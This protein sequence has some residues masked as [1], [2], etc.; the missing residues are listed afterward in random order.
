[1]HKKKKGK[2]QEERIITVIGSETEYVLNFNPTSNVVHYSS[3]V[4]Y[5]HFLLGINKK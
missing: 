3:S 4:H 5:K 1:M 2:G